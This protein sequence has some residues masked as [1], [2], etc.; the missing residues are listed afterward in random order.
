MVADTATVLA[1]V[2]TVVVVV[3]T[4]GLAAVETGGVL[5]LSF[6]EDGDSACEGVDAVRCGAAGDGVD[7]D[8]AVSLAGV[9]LA[10]VGVV[11]T[12]APVLGVE[13]E[14]PCVVELGTAVATATDL[15][16]VAAVTA[17]VVGG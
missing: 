16:L 10:V 8:D 3:G 6:T 13:T 12:A 17:L 14:S 1:G 7:D 9:T 4:T 15:E 2:A 5:G 11:A